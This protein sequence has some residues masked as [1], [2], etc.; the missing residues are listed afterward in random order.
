M[1]SRTGR[2]AAQESTYAASSLGGAADGRDG[3][4]GEPTE[5]DQ[6]HDPWPVIPRV[7]HFVFGLRPQDEPFH[8]VHYLAL[9]S[10]REIVQP[11]EIHVHCHELPYGFYWDLVRPDIVLHRVEPVA[12]VRDF[13]YHDPVVEHYSYAH[14]ADFV[15]LDVL[16]EHGGVY[17]DIDTL[18][19]APVHDDLWHE[20]CVLGIEHPVVDPRTG[21]PRTSLSNALVMAEPGASFVERWRARIDDALDGTWSAHSCFLADD[22]AREHPAEVHVEPERTFHAFAPTASGLRQ[23]LVEQAT[24]LERVA[25]IHLAAHLWWEEDRRDFVPEVHARLIDEAWVQRGGC[26]YAAAAAR[27][28]PAPGRA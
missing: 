12:A 23:L 3:M 17:A 28:L 13:H 22:L 4:A 15:R 19:V 1:S 16:A 26:T 24:D 9:A 14:H 25:S 21:V 5:A 18:F 8:L 20:P 27:F 10:C 6:W 11:D 2:R 7:V